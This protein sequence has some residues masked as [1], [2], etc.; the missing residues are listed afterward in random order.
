MENALVLQVKPEDVEIIKEKDY[1]HISIKNDAKMI[2]E[3]NNDVMLRPHG[4]FHIVSDGEMSF[5]SHNNIHM[6]TINSNIYLNSRQGKILK[7]TE[8]AID[9]RLKMA[10]E[11]KKTLLEA[12]KQNDFTLLLKDRVSILEQQM[13]EL[14]EK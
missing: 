9:Q 6:D 10:C 14:L 8:E 3:M 12:K 11:H 1:I 5:V 7:D 13:K 4:D 2:I